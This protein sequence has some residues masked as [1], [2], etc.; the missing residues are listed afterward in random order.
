MTGRVSSKP[1][2]LQVGTIA[3]LRRVDPAHAGRIVLV[4][5][6]AAPV[7]VPGAPVTMRAWRIYVLGRDLRISGSDLCS[8]IAAEPC[9]QPLCVLTERIA[10]A[11]SRTKARR[12]AEAAFEQ[13]R[14]LL[15]EH[16]I[17]DTQLDLELKIGAKEALARQAAPLVL[18]PLERSSCSF[19]SPNSKLQSE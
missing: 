1:P 9:L 10:R 8:L 15:E 2:V 4:E 3:Q 17:D 14:S 11:V 18:L 19:R 12:D 16:P 6:P 13:L 5:S 7:T